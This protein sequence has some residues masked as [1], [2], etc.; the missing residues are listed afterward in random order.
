MDI[1]VRA[2]LIQ[3][4]YNIEDFSVRVND[5]NFKLVRAKLEEQHKLIIQI[6]NGLS[7]QGLIK[8]IP[9]PQN[10]EIVEIIKPKN[11]KLQPELDRLISTKRELS[12]SIQKI[13]SLF[14]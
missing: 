10:K 12:K 3:D 8:S 14:K 6:L 9:N 11:K 7:L 5:V 13:K 2:F 4:I 1:I